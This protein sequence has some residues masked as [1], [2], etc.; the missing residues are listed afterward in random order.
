LT[1]EI[2]TDI[3]SVL[4]AEEGWEKEDSAGLLIFEQLDSQDVMVHL[5]LNIFLFFLSI[6]LD[7]I[8]LFF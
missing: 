7:L 8:F 1:I 4:C 6:F 2:T 5:D 3:T